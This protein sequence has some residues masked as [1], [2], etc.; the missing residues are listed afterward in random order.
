MNP[1]TDTAPPP[2]AAALLLR[3]LSGLS[4]FGPIFGKELRT[5]ARR[6]RSYVLRVAY[7]GGL[8]LA[9]LAAWA[10]TSARG[11]YAGIAALAIWFVV[12]VWWSFAGD[13]YTDFLLFVV[14][15]FIL[16]FVLF[17]GVLSRVSRGEDVDADGS[18]SPG[19]TFRAW[20]SREFDTWQY[21]LKGGNAA[22]EVLLPI[23]A[24]AFGMTAIGI[25]AH[26]VIHG[27]I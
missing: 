4:P 8:L 12:A 16:T 23:A 9:M 5:T 3:H 19:R 1:I 24:I 25:V 13:G 20:A 11:M 22:A 6:K 17:A 10:E 27:A 21:R 15:G 2:R 7:L 14:S 18:P 26:M